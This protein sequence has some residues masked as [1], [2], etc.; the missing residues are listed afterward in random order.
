MS[1][2]FAYRPAYP[3]SYKKL[4]TG[5]AAFLK[6]IKAGGSVLNDPNVGGFYEWELYPDYKIFMDMQVALLFRDEDYYTAVSSIR[7]EEVFRNV[8]LK[9]NPSFVTTPLKNSTFS[10]FAYK[11]PDYIPVFFDDVEA[12]YVNK[13]IH[14]DIA[15][16]YALSIHPF[17]LPDLKID[18]LT[19]GEITLLLDELLRIR[20]LYAGTKLT[21]SLIATIYNTKRE[22]TK[23]LLFSDT[24]I[25]SFPE[26]QDGYR[27]KG[28]ALM[29]L[30]RFDEAVL[31]YSMALDRSSD[32]LDKQRIYKRMLLCFYSTEQSDKAYTILKKS[33]NVFTPDKNYRDFYYFG[34]TAMEAGKLTESRMYF[35]FAE[36]NVPAHDA[37]W[38]NKIQ[39]QLSRFI[40]E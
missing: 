18:S 37:Q 34:L 4:P 26:L 25:K 1:H 27:L 9:Y 24:I 31:H 7:N 10:L 21:N 38:K 23:A 30:S 11:F 13:S 6:H 14:P 12:L 3:V 5:V 28:D 40:V 16:T 33:I 8:V 39:D 36:I 19:D 29:G 20:E 15:D 2:T 22:Y 35:K 32:K 17:L